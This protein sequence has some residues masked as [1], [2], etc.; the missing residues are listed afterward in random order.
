MRPVTSTKLCIRQL[1]RQARASTLNEAYHNA[2]LS[3][4]LLEH[5]SGWWSRN[6]KQIK[7]FDVAYGWLNERTHGKQHLKDY[8]DLQQSSR[9]KAVPGKDAEC[10]KIATRL[11]SAS[12]MP[13]LQPANWHVR[14]FKTAF[15]HRNKPLYT[16]SFRLS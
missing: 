4:L 7:S 2:S 16:Q 3:L 12:K 9:L 15:L 10:T 6:R 14:L 1:G 11:R 8:I 13:R 5:L